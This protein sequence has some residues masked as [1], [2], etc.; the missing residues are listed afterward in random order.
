MWKLITILS[1]FYSFVTAT[2]FYKNAPTYLCTD[3]VT[4][5]DYYTNYTTPTVFLYNEWNA[6][7]DNFC[8]P[9]HS[10][11]SAV[12]SSIPSKS[13]VLPT[14]YKRRKGKRVLSRR[15][16]NRML[17]NQTGQYTSR[18]YQPWVKYDQLCLSF[19]PIKKRMYQNRDKK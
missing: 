17:P 10:Y 5:Q 1:H 3:P 19:T 12:C 6:T 15:L 11:Y 9:Y 14:I 8:S 13:I 16:Y 4:F 7:T 18:Y 2:L